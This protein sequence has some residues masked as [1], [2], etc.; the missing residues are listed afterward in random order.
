MA[1]FKIQCWNNMST[2]R[3]SPEYV[4]LTDIVPN[5]VFYFSLEEIASGMYFQDHSPWQKS[6]YWV[7][8]YLTLFTKLGIEYEHKEFR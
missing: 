1:E 3:W 8:Q 5:L 4:Y 2:Y 6:Q 7:V